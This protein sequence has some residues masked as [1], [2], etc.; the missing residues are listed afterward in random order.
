MAED[1]QAQN[2][3]SQDPWQNWGETQT[4]HIPRSAEA[5]HSDQPNEETKSYAPSARNEHDTTFITQQ[6][7]PSS[8]DRLIPLKL[9]PI[10][11]PKSKE[12]KVAEVS[13]EQPSLPEGFRSNKHSLNSWDFQPSE[14]RRSNQH[15][16][17]KQ[18]QLKPCEPSCFKLSCS[19][20]NLPGKQHSQRRHEQGRPGPR[21]QEDRPNF[22]HPVSGAPEEATD[23]A[24]GQ[25]KARQRNN[26]PGIAEEDS[27]QHK[28][29][30]DCPPQSGGIQEQGTTRG[31][32]P[33]RECSPLTL[34]QHNCYQ[35]QEDR[36]NSLRAQGPPVKIP[37]RETHT[38]SNYT[39]CQ[40]GNKPGVKAPPTGLSG[41]SRTKSAE[42][43]LAQRARRYHKN[44]PTV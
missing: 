43:D 44:T 13:Q 22:Y 30:M 18:N 2:W 26:K 21:Q 29:R 33:V 25:D 42:I 34:Q 24:E 6:K 35:G 23:P 36:L 28:E 37:S 12:P 5:H 15:D 17:A 4:H 1:A 39:G 7:L 14:A 38:F 9:A 27:H 11:E 20:R 40:M 32:Q 8:F 31:P 16:S 10:L 19:T 41:T 3:S